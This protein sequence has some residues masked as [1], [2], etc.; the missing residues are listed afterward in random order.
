[1]PKVKIEHID[2]LSKGKKS[3]IKLGSRSVPHHLYIYER[4]EYERAL[5]RW[6]LIVDASDRVNLEN[7]W[8]LVCEAR[9]CD[10]LI[11]H[12]DHEY[13]T[14]SSGSDEIFSWL[15]CDAKIYLKNL[16]ILWSR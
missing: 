1:M 11:L 13:G 9:K 14:I 5:K 2:A 10:C 6:Y 16:P 15:L 4:E 7:L 12:K 8:M 3:G